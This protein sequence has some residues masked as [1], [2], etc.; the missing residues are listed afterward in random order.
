MRK[1]KEDRLGGIALPA[2]RVAGVWIW[3][4]DR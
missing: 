2:E 3:D 4:D 1:K